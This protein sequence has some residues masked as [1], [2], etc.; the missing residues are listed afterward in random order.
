M[1]DLSL[2]TGPAEI[3]E[4]IR[5]HLG[6]H[7]GGEHH[8]CLGGGSVLAA[9]WHHRHSTNL[10][11]FIQRDPYA[12]LHA[13]RCRFQH[14]LDT[15]AGGLRK[16][17][18]LPD[19]TYIIL[20]DGGEISVSTPPS[21][22]ANPRSADTVRGTQIALETTDEILARKIGG[23]LLG[24]NIFVPRD[25]Y[26]IVAARH[27]D[28][29]GLDRALRPFTPDQHEQIAEELG[30]LPPDWMTTHP[31]PVIAPARPG[32]VRQAIFTVRAILQQSSR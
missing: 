3:L 28:P 32:A 12:R 21:L 30:R 1:A 31:Q 10:D 26:D 17:A 16:L 24:N 9:R 25:L 13:N 20:A 5:T 8:L 11:F 15:V 27:F 14:D 22:T 2:P 4:R 18:V 6:T 29:N 23:R 7:L 19:H